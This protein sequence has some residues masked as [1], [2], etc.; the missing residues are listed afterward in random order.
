MGTHPIFESDFDCLTE[1]QLQPLKLASVDQRAQNQVKELL[2]PVAQPSDNELTPGLLQRKPP[3]TQLDNDKLVICGNFTQK[4][5]PASR[6]VQFQY[7][8]C[9][10]CSSP[11]FFILHIWGKYTRS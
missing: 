8:L 7:W 6:L 2:V 3:S 1:C 9:R 4:T 11:Q 5:V 10:S